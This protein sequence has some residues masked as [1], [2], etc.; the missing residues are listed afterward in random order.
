MTT[1]HYGQQFTGNRHTPTDCW[2]SHPTTRHH[3][4]PQR[5]AQLVC[6]TTD[7]LSEGNKYLDRVFSKN[8]YDEDLIRRNTHRPTT[9]TTEAN[10]N[11]TLTTTATIPYLKGISENISRILQPFIIRVA[12]KPL[13]H[14]VS[15]WL[16]SKTKTN[17]G[18]D[19]E[20]FIR[21]TA[22]TGTPSTSVRLA[23]NLTTR[24]TEHKRATK[25]RCQQSHCW[26]SPTYEPHYRLRLCAMPYPQHQLLSANDSGKLVY[27]LGTDYPQQ[28]STTTGTIQTTHPWH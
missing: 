20:Q 28:V 18:T 27:K 25:R 24:L 2:T 26:T 10:D 6:N 21:S 14:Y 22:P 12:Y 13:P 11:A 8:N 7:S 4:K 19:R 5:R 17:Q 1:T 15:N 23:E 3:T 9:T 16:T